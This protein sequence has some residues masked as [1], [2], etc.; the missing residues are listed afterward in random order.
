M[1]GFSRFMTPFRP[2][3]L[4]GLWPWL[5]ACPPPPAPPAAPVPGPADAGL[6]DRLRTADGL[7]TTAGGVLEWQAEPVFLTAGQSFARLVT[8]PPGSCWYFLAL[9]GNRIGDLDLT[10]FDLA[11]R[12]LD[13]DDQ[14]DPHP[15]IVHCVSGEAPEEAVVSP[16]AYEGTGEVVVALYRF[17]PDGA[18]RRGELDFE[19]AAPPAG[20]TTETPEEALERMDRLMRAEGF[21]PLG[22]SERLELSGRGETARPRR[23]PAGTCLGVAL[24]GDEDA[25]DLDLRLQLGSR[26]VAEDRERSRDAHV[27]YCTEAEVDLRIYAVSAQGPAG[28]TLAYY[29]ARPEDRVFVTPSELPDEPRADEAGGGERSF[30]QAA[31]ELD[32]A[33]RAGG[34]AREGA[35]IEGTLAIGEQAVQRLQ[36]SRG[37]CYEIAALPRPGGIRD[38]DLLLDDGAG[39]RVAEDRLE[40]NEPRIAFC[41][42]RTGTYQLVVHAYDGGGGYVAWVYRLG[43]TTSDLPGISGRLSTAYAR[44]SAQLFGKGFHPVGT[45]NQQ[46]AD[47]GRQDSHALRLEHGNCYVVAALASDEGMDID[48]EVRDYLLRGVSVDV[49][50]EPDARVFVC[51]DRTAEFHA[52][53]TVAR[54]R[55]QYMLVLFENKAERTT[56]RDADPGRGE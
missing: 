46:P 48:I 16:L 18:P 21:R 17:P 41:P 1:K 45:P 24:V 3:L 54:G 10:L 14:R 37:S 47:A 39:N 7:L 44:L 26:K 31:L 5:A 32:R 33:L 49:A 8:L 28:G 27:T 9:A 2:L 36:L 13:V 11:G 38:L 34:F 30:E 50:R 4:L 52:T 6:A 23:V 56:A 15:V 20:P 25:I 42:D 22:D 55:G 53:V 35:P 40:T 43:A 12:R 29:E 51:P 19:D